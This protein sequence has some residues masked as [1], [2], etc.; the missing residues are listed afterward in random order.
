MK[1]GVF[2][3]TRK[4]VMPLLPASLFV[5]VNRT[6]ASALGPTVIQFFEP[7]IT[8]SSPRRTAVVFCAAASLPASGSVR[9]KQP[10]FS[11]RA[12]GTRNSCF[13]ASVPNF[14]TGS[15]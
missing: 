8:Y 13:C 14:I 12:N 3:G 10:S 4:A 5:M 9:P 11:P 7:L 1:P 6:M 2:V 15:Q